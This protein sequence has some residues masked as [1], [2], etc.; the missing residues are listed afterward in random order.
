MMLVSPTSYCIA[1]NRVR[2]LTFRL[3]YILGKNSTYFR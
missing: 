2:Q 3:N 1:I